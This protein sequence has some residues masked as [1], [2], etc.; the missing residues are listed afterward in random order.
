MDLIQWGQG[1]GNPQATN[2]NQPADAGG[3]AN[4]TKD[5]SNPPVDYKGFFE[6]HVQAQQSRRDELASKLATTTDEREKFNVEK[7]IFEIE[8]QLHQFGFGPQ[9][10]KVSVPDNIPEEAKSFIENI[11]KGLSPQEA[12]NVIDFASGLISKVQWEA[13]PQVANLND[14]PGDNASNPAWG[15]NTGWRSQDMLGENGNAAKL[16]FMQLFSD[17]IAKEHQ[18]R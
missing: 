15:N 10:Q 13:K 12:K 1:G 14:R 6:S 7:E 9:S 16:N 2:V 11:T 3:S 5:V 18:R 8:K 4:P 17:V